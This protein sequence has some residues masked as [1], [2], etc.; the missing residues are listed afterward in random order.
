M[1]KVRFTVRALVRVRVRFSTKDRAKSGLW[2]QFRMGFEL[3][4]VL[5][6]SPVPDWGG[7]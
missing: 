1:C 5:W 2:L 6:L 4:L 3:S 7:D